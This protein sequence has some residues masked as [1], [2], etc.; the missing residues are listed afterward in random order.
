MGEKERERE[1]ER[2]R[3]D[4]IVLCNL[5]ANHSDKAPPSRKKYTIP[6]NTLSNSG[7]KSATRVSDAGSASDLE[8]LIV[9]TNE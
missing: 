3:D 9:T 4:L 5:H 6:M 8:L 2:E 7:G 1:R